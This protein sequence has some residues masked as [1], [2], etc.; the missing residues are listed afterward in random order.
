MI[1]LHSLNATYNFNLS[2][3]DV[4][5]RPKY[6]MSFKFFLDMTPEETVINPSSLTKFRKLRLKDMNLLN[7]LIS[8]TGHKTA[9]T[10][11]LGYKTHIAMT[12]ERTITAA[13]ITS[14][15][16]KSYSETLICDSH[17]EQA[18]QQPHRLIYFS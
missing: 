16:K 9:D 8:K 17:S 3:I 5:E 1:F 6:D 10:S 7:M 13:T 2:D 11:F 4:V 14:S 18:K 15:E 12:E